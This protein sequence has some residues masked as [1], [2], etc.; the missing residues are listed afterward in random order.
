MNETLITLTNQEKKNWVADA[1]SEWSCQ[2]PLMIAFQFARIIMQS[3]TA[4][5]IT[6]TGV[7]LVQTDMTASKAGFLLNFALMITS[8][9]PQT[10]FPLT[11]RSILPTRKSSFSRADLCQC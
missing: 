8:G 2:F 11:Y 5:V 10:M 3:M 6:A 7:L 1:H 9:K 4:I